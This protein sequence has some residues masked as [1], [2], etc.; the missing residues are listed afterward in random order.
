MRPVDPSLQGQ[1]ALALADLVQRLGLLPAETPT[2]PSSELDPATVGI[3]VLVAETVTWPDA[4]L[5]CRVAGMRY[6]QL[7]VDGS[8]I[9]LRYRER[10]YAYHT[11]GRRT[12]PFL[13]PRPG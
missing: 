3:E 7:P 1:I 10:S 12:V 8:R 9:V 5:G 6:P 11:G 2:D 13:C 4:G